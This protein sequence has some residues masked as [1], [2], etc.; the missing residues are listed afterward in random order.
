MIVDDVNSLDPDAAPYGDRIHTSA[1]RVETAWGRKL[2]VFESGDGALVVRS[3]GVPLKV[4]DSKG[5]FLASDGEVT[6]S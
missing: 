1:L 2:L 6:I 5:I 3:L 4:V